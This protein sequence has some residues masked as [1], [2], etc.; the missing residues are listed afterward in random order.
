VEVTQ[1]NKKKAQNNPLLIDTF[2][3]DPVRQTRGALN[4]DRRK[5]TDGR[6]A[7]T[8]ERRSKSVKDISALQL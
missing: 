2:L 7:L 5:Q 1:T 4:T 3:V 8:L 6:V